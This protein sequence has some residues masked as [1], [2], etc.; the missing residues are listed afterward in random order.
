MMINID[1]QIIVY[2]LLYLLVG[3]LVA[4]IDLYICYIEKNNNLFFGERLLLTFSEMIFW[5]LCAF[6]L[7]GMW[8]RGEIF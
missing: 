1:L 2:I 4:I 6:V 5:P 8:F 7:F 3:N